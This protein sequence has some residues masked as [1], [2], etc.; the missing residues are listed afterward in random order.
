MMS[1]QRTL[2]AIS[3][4]ISQEELAVLLNLLNI[5]RLPGFQPPAQLDSDVLNTALHGLLSRGIAQM[6][7]ED[8]AV[9]ET[10]ASIVAAGAITQKAVNVVYAAPTGERSSG[11]FYLLPGL[12]VYH[13]TPISGVHHFETIPDGARFL[14]AMAGAMRLSSSDE[15]EGAGEPFDLPKAAWDAALPAVLSGDSQGAR[16]ALGG[17]PAN[18]VEAV[19]AVQAVDVVTSIRTNSQNQLDTDALLALV[20]SRGYYLVFP[21]DQPDT[22]RV[23]PTNTIGILDAAAEL[24]RA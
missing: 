22:L 5:P 6:Q 15:S 18:F 13:A 1:E 16:R 10:V 14:V 21:A 19:A 24:V 12:T 17:T 20:S 8:A 2:P 23:I 11:W 3:V 4:D 7:A 9:D